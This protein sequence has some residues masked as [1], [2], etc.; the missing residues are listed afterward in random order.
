MP[1]SD[2]SRE[3]FDEKISANYDR[4]HGAVVAVKQKYL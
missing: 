2:D 4:D 1:L 3:F